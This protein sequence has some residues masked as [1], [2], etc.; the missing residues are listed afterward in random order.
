MHI[1]LYV[2]MII[3]MYVNM[4]LCRY[5]YMCIC[6]Y[7]CILICAYILLLLLVTTGARRIACIAPLYLYIASTI[8]ATRAPSIACIPS[9]WLWIASTIGDNGSPQYR[10]NRL[11]LA[12]IGATDACLQANAFLQQLLSHMPT[13]CLRTNCTKNSLYYDLELCTQWIHLRTSSVTRAHCR[14]SM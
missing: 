9:L 4:Y 7:V 3:C 1:C 14:Y 5:I 8:G 2:C 13:V 12:S 11:F 6:I 10:Y